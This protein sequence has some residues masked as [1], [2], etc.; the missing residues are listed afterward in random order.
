M[1]LQAPL[2]AEVF[3]HGMLKRLS[4]ALKALANLCIHT[5]QVRTHFTCFTGTKVLRSALKALANLCI[6]TLQVLS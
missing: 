4:S 6:H 5:L 2:Q 3:E 1:L